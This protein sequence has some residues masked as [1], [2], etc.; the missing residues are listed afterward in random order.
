MARYVAVVHSPLSPAEAFSRLADLRNFAEW[1][2]GVAAAEQVQGGPD[3]VYDLTLAPPSAPVTLRYRVVTFDPP[4]RVVVEA[5][6]ALLRSRDTMWVGSLDSG[7]LVVYD[8]ELSLPFPLSL[9][10]PL[11]APVFRIIG[12]RAAAGLRRFLEA[13][14]DRTMG[15]AAAGVDAVGGAA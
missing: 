11:L 14:P 4:H 1:D 3:A 13:E 8:A 6:N 10:D 7:A 5:H 15:V 9:G 2:P 12:D